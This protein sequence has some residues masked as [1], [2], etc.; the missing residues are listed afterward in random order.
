MFLLLEVWTIEQII[1][2]AGDSRRHDALLKE[3]LVEVDAINDH[4]NMFMICA[5]ICINMPLLQS[6]MGSELKLSIIS[7]AENSWT[8]DYNL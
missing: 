6:V 2:L 4:W 5:V 3:G 1:E 7:A 8:I